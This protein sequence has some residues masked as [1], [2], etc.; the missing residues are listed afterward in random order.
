MGQGGVFT[1]TQGVPGKQGEITI[2]DA[3]NTPIVLGEVAIVKG[4]GW[5]VPDGGSRRV[6]QCSCLSL[7]EEGFQRLTTALTVT[8]QSTDSENIHW[9]IMEECLGPSVREEGNQTV[10]KARAQALWAGERYTNKQY[11]GE[12]DVIRS[13]HGRQWRKESETDGSCLCKR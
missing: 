13:F 7:S 11:E 4:P 2:K 8:G 1:L 3:Q 5:A 6:D 9:M 12:V 10:L